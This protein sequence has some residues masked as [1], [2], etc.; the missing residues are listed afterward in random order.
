VTE[1]H[2]ASLVSS[3]NL[4]YVYKWENTRKAADQGKAREQEKTKLPIQF[5]MDS[6]SLFD[7]LSARPNLTLTIDASIVMEQSKIEEGIRRC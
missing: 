5:L 4:L 1:D 3:A 6:S 2:A 7:T